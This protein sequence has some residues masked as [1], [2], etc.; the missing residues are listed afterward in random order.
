MVFGLVLD[1]VRHGWR[2]QGRSDRERNSTQLKRSGAAKE[3]E[4]KEKRLSGLPLF[5][6]KPPKQTFYDSGE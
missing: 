5:V 3:A 6:A 1:L 2:R 4:E